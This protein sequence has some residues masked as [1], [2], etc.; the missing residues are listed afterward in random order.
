MDKSLEPKLSVSSVELGNVHFKSVHTFKIEV[1]DISKIDYWEVSCPCT[2]VKFN[3]NT[4]EGEFNVEHAIGVQLKSGETS[5]KYRYID[6]FLNPE[7]PEFKADKV[8]KKK[9]RNEEKVSIRIPINYVAF[10]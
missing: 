7:V 8:T 3:G 1:D 9:I 2:K 5:S 4:I 6:L 10:G